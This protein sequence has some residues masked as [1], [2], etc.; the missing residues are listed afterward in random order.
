MSTIYLLKLASWNLALFGILF[1][2]NTPDI[3]WGQMSFKALSN[4]W[5]FGALRHLFYG[6]PAHSVV[7]DSTCNAGDFQE[8]WAQSLGWEDSLKKEMANHSNIL[9]WRIPWTKEPGR[10]QSMGLQRVGHDWATRQQQQHWFWHVNI[11]LYQLITPL[12]PCHLSILVTMFLSLWIRLPFVMMF[13][14]IH[15]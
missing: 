1:W 6:F 3:S 15:F 8:T 2:W 12:T 13:I 9:A 10:L 4:F 7:K 11:N 5:L 14:C